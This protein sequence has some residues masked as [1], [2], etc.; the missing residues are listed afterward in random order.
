[1]KKNW[2]GIQKGKLHEIP[3]IQNRSERRQ[4]RGARA[5]HFPKNDQN[6]SSFHADVRQ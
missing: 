2:K 6:H 4:K 5:R 3:Q 1:M